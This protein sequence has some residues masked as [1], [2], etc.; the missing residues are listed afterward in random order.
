MILKVTCGKFTS[1]WSELA[2]KVD[3]W[4]LWKP[5]NTIKCNC[6]GFY[7]SARRYVM[8]VLKMHDMIIYVCR[9][10]SRKVLP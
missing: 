5:S 2:E 10:Q 3:A 6:A 4:K 8:F 9:F 7:N 1:G